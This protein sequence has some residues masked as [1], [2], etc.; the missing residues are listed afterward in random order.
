MKENYISGILNI[1]GTPYRTRLSKHFANKKPYSPPD[2]AII[3]SFIPGTVLDILVSEGQEVSEG[4]EL[5]ILDA[6]KMQNM[7][8][9]PA[10]G[11]IEKILVSKGERVSKGSMLI[12]IA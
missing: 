8:K 2:P 4:D 12:R 6:M 5:M 11:V 3:T 7:L 10:C 1:D 9:S